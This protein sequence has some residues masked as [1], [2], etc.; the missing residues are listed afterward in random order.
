MNPI[1]SNKPAKGPSSENYEDS[2]TSVS[3][4]LSL[5]M[6]MI[7]SPKN[8]TYKETCKVCNC[9][10]S[11]MNKKLVCKGCGEPMCYSHS[12]L[13]DKY[14]LERVCDTCMHQI[15]FK[16]AEEEIAEIKQ[17][18]YGELSFS[19]LEREE[20]TRLINKSIGKLRK[21]ELESKEKAEKFK[22]DEELA[23][24]KLESSVEEFRKLQKEIE[25]YKCFLEWEY[26]EEKTEKERECMTYEDYNAHTILVTNIEQ[27]AQEL[28]C[29]AEVLKEKISTH[30]SIETLNQNICQICN[31]M[32]MEEMPQ[33]FKPAFPSRTTN[34]KKFQDI[35]KQICSCRII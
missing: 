22:Q 32:L 6:S 1:D 17:R 19:L 35:S 33:T 15:L 18:Y 11:L 13:L 24:K 34:M 4:R 21:L 5:S 8:S 20:K 9:L 2:P 3:H 28:N 23:Q 31:Q 16:Q 7:S 25:E 10:F 27:N 26:K 29:Q 12:C 30:I 14:N